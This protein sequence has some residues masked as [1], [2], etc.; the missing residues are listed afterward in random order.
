M[1]FA[2]E[3]QLALY[4]EIEVRPDD[5]LRSEGRGGDDIFWNAQRIVPWLVTD[6]LKCLPDGRVIVEDINRKLPDLPK[7]H[8]ANWRDFVHTKVEAF[9]RSLQP[10][11]EQKPGRVVTD[12]ESLAAA[13]TIDAKIER[14]H[15]LIHEALR[16][17]EY[18]A[19]ARHEARIKRCLNSRY[20][21]NISQDGAS[22]QVKET[23]LDELLKSVGSKAA[24]QVLLLLEGFKLISAPDARGAFIRNFGAIARTKPVVKTV[25]APTEV[26]EVP[27]EDNE[28]ADVPLEDLL[29][30]VIPSHGGKSKFRGMPERQLLLSPQ[31]SDRVIARSTAARL[32]DEEEDFVVPSRENLRTHLA[33]GP[34]A[35]FDRST[36]DV[37]DLDRYFGL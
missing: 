2:K 30:E 15:L 6:S 9:N 20:S 36:T 12:L 29:P 21:L 16:R 5:F 10:K 4:R 25:A 18:E 1:D 11:Y 27:T 32:T 19:I 33:R 28:Q 37:E 8:K 3:L 13:P 35:L 23:L 26:V 24:P 14:L 22:I 17:P 31:L 34:R 7:Q